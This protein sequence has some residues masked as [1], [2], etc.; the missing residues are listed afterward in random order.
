MQQMALKVK[1]CAILNQNWENKSW[2][3]KRTW[4]MAS[5]T[6]RNFVKNKE[7]ID[8]LSSRHRISHSRGVL[9]KETQTQQSITS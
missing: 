1:K 8:V 4:G 3:F 2:V 9:K 6:I 7:T 5:T